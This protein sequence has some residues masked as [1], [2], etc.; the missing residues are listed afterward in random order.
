MY[1]FLFLCSAR[2]G[3]E[4]LPPFAARRQRKAFFCRSIFGRGGKRGREANC[5]SACVGC[6]LLVTGEVRNLLQHRMHE[7]SAVWYLEVW[8]VFMRTLSF[9]FGSFRACDVRGLLAD[10][11][12]SGGRFCCCC[13]CGCGYCLVVIVA[14]AC[15]CGCGCGCG[16]RTAVVDVAVVAA[17]VVW[18]WFGGCMVD[19]TNDV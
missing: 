10:C 1:V 3:P 4:R 2:E 8:C 16:C 17:V 15:D 5:C 6:W 12:Q 9:F 7:S 13:G 18:L 14:M 19:G 11:L